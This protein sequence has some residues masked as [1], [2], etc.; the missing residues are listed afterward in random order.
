MLIAI[1]GLQTK[2]HS[3]RGIFLL[4]HPATAGCNGRLLLRLER[5]QH[6][7]SE[8]QAEIG[9]GQGY[10][11]VQSHPTATGRRTRLERKRQ[12]VAVAGPV[13]VTFIDSLICEY[14]VTVRVHLL[15]V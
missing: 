12:A 5:K 7:K 6:L 15:L 13:H 2:T 10:F 8:R 14:N 1:L 4:W 11:G 3:R 9:W